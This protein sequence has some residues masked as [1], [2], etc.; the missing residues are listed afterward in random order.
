MFGWIKNT[1][2]R[3][4]YID[5]LNLPVSLEQEIANQSRRYAACGTHYTGAKYGIEKG[6]RLALYLYHEE[7]DKLEGTHEEKVKSF[8]NRVLYVVQYRK[9]K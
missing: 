2:S 9:L 8:I 5:P 6:L 7:M 1:F 4:K 3:K